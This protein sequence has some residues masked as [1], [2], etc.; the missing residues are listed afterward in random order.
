MGRINV[1]QVVTRLVVRGVPRHVLELAAGLDRDRFQVDVLAGRGEPGEG[2]LWAEAHQR[3]I[4]TMYLD[5]LQRSVSPVADVRALARLYTVMRRGQYHIVHTHISKAGVLGRLAARMARV[6]VIIHTYHGEVAEVAAGGTAARLFRWMEGAMARSTHRFI[7]VSQNTVKEC[8][9]RGVGRAEQY[10][11]IYNGID[12]EH[13]TRRHSARPFDHPGA[14]PVIGLVG[15]LTA[16]K[17]VDVLLEAVRQVLENH[18]GLLLC[19]VGDGPLRDR[20]QALTGQLGL[21]GNA[22]FA[23]LVPDVRPWLTHFDVLVSPS[24]REGLPTVLLEA[25]AMGCPVVATRVG[26]IPEI[27]EPGRTGLLVDPNDPVGLASAINAVVNN[28]EQRHRMQEEGHR[29]A[30]A[31]FGLDT[32]L[33]RTAA[34]Y[35]ELHDPGRS[36]S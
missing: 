26:G 23:G 2:S 35:E 17:R 8:L 34:A 14:G 16:E 9:A 10:Q 32:M 19:V 3:G 4:R 15:S 21:T 6:P 36:G 29:R 11:V 20:L 27:I 31:R 18:E 33:S 24:E 30:Q 5:A 25:M 7:A 22:L 1:L 13:F 12:L 28:P